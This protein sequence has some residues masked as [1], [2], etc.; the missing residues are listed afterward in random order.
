MDTSAKLDIDLR[1]A[2]VERKKEAGSRCLGKQRDG[3]FALSVSVS[4]ACFSADQLRILADIVER[5]AELGHLSTGQSF[6]L[7]GIKQ[8]DYYQ[9]RQAVLDAGFQLRSVGRDVFHV[10]CCPGADF[11]P[12]G[13]QRT[14][15]LVTE[16]EETF[17]AL[18]MPQK[19]KIALS[20]CTNCCANTR[21]AEFGLHATMKGWKIFVGGKMGFA[22]LVSQE[23]AG[24]VEAEQ[25]PKYLAAVLRCYRELAEPNER[26]ALTIPRVGFEVFKAAVKQA[27]EVPFDDLAQEALESRRAMEQMVVVGLEEPGKD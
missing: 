19:F 9:A 25:V 24:P 1:K 23:L 5:Y 7:L 16:L 18:P 22:P 11:S 3:R 20:G 14:F 12:F 17:R 2:T 8:Q 26:L 27:L 4:T 15:N 10:K 21:L 13:L 6:V